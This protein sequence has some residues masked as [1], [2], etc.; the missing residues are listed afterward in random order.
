[1]QAGAVVSAHWM[2]E[3]HPEGTLLAEGQMLGLAATRLVV[4]V[5]TR[6]LGRVL[7]RWVR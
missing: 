2:T 5:V 3:Q 4:L 7:R 6:P 1:M